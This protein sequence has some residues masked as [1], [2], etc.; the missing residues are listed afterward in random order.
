LNLSPKQDNLYPFDF[1]KKY[2]GARKENMMDFN[3]ET[4]ATRITVKCA[5]RLDVAS[6]K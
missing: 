3:I 2:A 1:V 4:R 5:G 6:A